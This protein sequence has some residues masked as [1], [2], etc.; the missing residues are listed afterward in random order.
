MNNTRYLIVAIC[1]SG[2]FEYRLD[3][4]NAQEIHKKAHCINKFYVI[5]EDILFHA[6]LYELVNNKYKLVRE[7]NFATH[8]PE[9][10]KNIKDVVRC[11]VWH[12]NDNRS[13]VLDDDSAYQY[14][15]EYRSAT[16]I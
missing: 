5:F 13:I 1:K 15:E 6:T 3:D 11:I 16:Q 9:N 7:I 8:K 2:I 12:N 14:I 4:Y 10:M